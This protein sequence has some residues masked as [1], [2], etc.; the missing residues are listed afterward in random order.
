[1]QV[2]GCGGCALLVKL[3][4]IFS[5]KIG[6]SSPACGSILKDEAAGLAEV[7]HYGEAKGLHLMQH[8]GT[9]LAAKRADGCGRLGLKNRG[10]LLGFI[11][12]RASIHFCEALVTHASQARLPLGMKR[13]L[14]EQLG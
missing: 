9:L 2:F 1:V 12:L 10:C 8:A 13:I 6:L 3:A 5:I 11:L 14:L 4:V 7:I